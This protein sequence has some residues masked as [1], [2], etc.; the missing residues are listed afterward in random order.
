M[1]APLRKRHVAIGKCDKRCR[2]HDSRR[3]ADGPR[4]ERLDEVR[5]AKLTAPCD[6]QVNGDL[7]LVP[8]L[9]SVDRFVRTLYAEVADAQLT[10]QPGSAGLRDGDHDF[11]DC[12]AVVDL[13]Q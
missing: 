13:T 10:Q 11:A 2:I 1:C 7:D 6:G 3:P 8:G 5:A 9:T 4:G 12:A